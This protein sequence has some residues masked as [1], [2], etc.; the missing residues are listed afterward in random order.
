M[1]YDFTELNKAVATWVNDDTSE[2]TRY[3]FHEP[4]PNNITCNVGTT[5]MLRVAEDG[6]YVRGEK[7]PVDD[8]EAAT[9]Y[10]AFKEFLVWSRLHRD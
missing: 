6:F 9:V 4:K 7:I 8:K 3:N 2:I 1:A 10:N 5:E